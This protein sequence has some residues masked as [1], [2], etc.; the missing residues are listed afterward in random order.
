MITGS[1]IID[2][3]FKKKELKDTLILQNAQLLDLGRAITKF[4]NLSIARNSSELPT[5]PTPVR[6][7]LW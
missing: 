3:E 2:L 7:W 1:E 4:Q 6:C 5:Q